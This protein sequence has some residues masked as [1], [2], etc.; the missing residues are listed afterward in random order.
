MEVY[1]SERIKIVSSC[2]CYIINILWRSC[3]MI[4][5]TLQGS[6][7]SHW[8]SYWLFSSLLQV[9]NP[10]LFT[11]YISPFNS[12]SLQ[13]I[14]LWFFIQ[15]N[16]LPYTFYFTQINFSLTYVPC[17]VCGCRYGY[18]IWSANISTC[19]LFQRLRL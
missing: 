7:L 2:I 11:I 18:E 10:N 6:L 8:Y 15:I 1:K 5:W 9:K 17:I 3:C 12:M 14:T 13:Y 4:G 16:L 19:T